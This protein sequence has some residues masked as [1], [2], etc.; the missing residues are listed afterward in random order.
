MQEL[1]WTGERMM[2]YEHLGLGAAEHL[3]R[4]AVAL[5]ITVGKIVLD[6]ACGEGYGSNLIAEK[7]EKV[8]GVDIAEDAIAHAS[9]NYAGNNLNFLKGSVTSIP[10][11]E[12]TIDI[13]ICFET[14]EHITEHDEM[15][16]EFK[17]VLKEDGILLM[18]TP[19]KENYESLNHNNPFHLKELSGEEFKILCKKYFKTIALYKQRYIEASFFYHEETDIK[20]ITEYEGSFE[21]VIKNDFTQKYYYNIVVCSNSFIPS[22][23]TSFFNAHQFNNSYRQDVI[24]RVKSKIENSYQ[25]SY[26]YRIGKFIIS[27]FSFIK[28]LF[29]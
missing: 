6:I 12:S 1:K 13:I 15:M 3:H 11:E 29:K 23:K 19:A 16:K 2:P 18:S 14:I 24:K 17:R 9:K 8:Y 27:P 10:L 21:A 25:K 26:S 4:Y 28:K 7:A 22:L 5:E 20:E